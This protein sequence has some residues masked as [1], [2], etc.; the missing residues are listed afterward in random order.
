MIKI[1]CQKCENTFYTASRGPQTQCPYCNYAT[2][3]EELNRRV[4][5]RAFTQKLCGILKGEVRIPAKT[6]DISDT[7]VGIKMMGY[8]PFDMDDT[9][10]V[11]VE[12]LDIEKKARVV[13]TKNFYGISRAGLKFC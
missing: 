8:L 1:N 7:G 2:K 5:E 13:W 10:D 11:F 12:E 4:K 9:V 6:V 3:Q